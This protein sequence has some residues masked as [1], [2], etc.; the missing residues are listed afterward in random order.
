[1]KKVFIYLLCEPDTQTVRYVGKTTDPK[2]RI[3]EHITNKHRDDTRRVRWINKLLTDGKLPQLRVIETVCESAW[4]VAE[5]KWIAFFRA[6]G[7]N[8]LNLTDG[9]DGVHNPSEESRKKLSLTRKL[10]FENPDYRK[11]ME[12]FAKNPERRAK[13]SSALKGKSKSP[14]H[15]AKLPQNRRGRKLTP[16]H[17]R[18]IGEHSRG[19]QYFK[20]HSH[21]PETRRKI[22]LSLIG[23][24]NTLGRKLTEE[25]KTRRSVALKG[26]PKADDH[27][28]KIQQ[29]L[30]RAWDR[31]KSNGEFDFEKFAAK[32]SERNRGEGS[33]R[34]KLTEEDVVE[35]R[36]R[37]AAGGITI[38]ELAHQ[39]HVAN[40]CIS[41][42]ITRKTWK[43]LIE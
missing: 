41:N 37:Y 20:G 21:S 26:R 17:K 40:S 18:K 24:K 11:R 30:L 14:E 31:R 3:H 36:K 2:R 42:V 15:I 16:S 19:N 7:L 25:E 33:A 12:E 4:E 27:K 13:I 9:G 23:N 28:Q 32:I 38:Q 6:K 34:A 29:G 35:I 22:S 1:M 5:Q 39:Y 8:L 43:H 10:M